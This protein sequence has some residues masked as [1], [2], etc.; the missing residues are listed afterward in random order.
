MYNIELEFYDT[1]PDRLLSN[2]WCLS[3]QLIGV[4]RD[5]I[6]GNKS[7]TAQVERYMG[8]L[9]KAINDFGLQAIALKT[10]FD[11]AEQ[12]EPFIIVDYVLYAW[13]PS[14]HVIISPGALWK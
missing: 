3:V 11:D 5:M 6:E 2:G 4:T 8:Y 9:E 13:C 1:I 7:L 12:E 10:T 14:L